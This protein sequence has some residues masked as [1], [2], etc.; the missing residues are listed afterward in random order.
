MFE[1]LK[2]IFKHSAIY[3]VGNIASKIIGFLMIPLYTRYLTT[4]DYGVVELLDITVAI[5]SELLAMGFAYAVIRFYYDYKNE[6]EKNQVIS[7]A[8][9]FNLSCALVSV[10]LLI[11][12]ADGLSLLIFGKARYSTFLQIIFITMFFEICL[13]V[14]FAYLRAI[15]A[16]VYY[17]ALMLTRL[18]IGLSWNIYFVVILKKGVAG[19][20]FSGLITG[21]ISFLFIVPLVFYKTGFHF[22]VKKLKGMLHFGLPLVPD[23]LAMFILNFV[24]RY[25]LRYF[26]TL[27]YV[28][29]YSLGHKF[30][31]MLNFLIT[32]SF[33]QIWTASIFSIANR[34]DAKELYAR[35]AT[36][37]GYVIIFAG[38]A[39]SVLI[40][41]ILMVM[42]APSFLEARKVVPL[43]VIGYVFMGVK[44]IFDVGFYLQKKTKYI[45]VISWTT[46]SITIILNGLLI[47]KY[48]MI[49]AGMSKALSFLFL[50]S[51]TYY[52]SKRVYFVP[53]EFYRIFKL[54]VV[55]IVIYFISLLIPSGSFLFSFLIKGILV[56]SFPFTLYLL[57]FY[58]PEEKAKVKALIKNKFY[59]NYLINLKE[60]KE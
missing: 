18:I 22:S 3:G 5:A 35:I 28:G 46:A 26:S 13:V 11:N 21:I 56:C 49:G 23:G 40:K 1:E 55:A 14:P 2:S 19:I 30:G 12:L 7:T 41:E 31:I 27:S 6:E 17:T 29:L 54:I 43:I 10:I 15:K 34:K 51:L 25:F 32:L 52:I 47:S 39:L 20:L 24:D 38:L 8:L 48:A 53:Y 50:T 57:K 37:F 58:Y 42:A 36:Y 45:P 16:S 9:I 4:A 59:L 60:R 44:Y 33:L